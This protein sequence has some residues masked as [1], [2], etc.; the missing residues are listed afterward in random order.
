[1]QPVSQALDEVKEL[2]QKV[3]G[4]PAPEIQPG[5]FVSF[6]PGV[7]PLDHVVKEVDQ[8]KHLSERMTFAPR[9]AAW[10]P[11]ADTFVTP[12]H[13]LVRM[14]IPGVDRETLKVFIVGGEC[15]VR[16]DRKF[17]EATPGVR[18]LNLERAWGPFERRFTLPTGSYPDKVVARYTDGVLEV[19]VAVE[20]I[21]KPREMNVE[22][23]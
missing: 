10:T 14:E 4:K 23:A 3:L 13:Y 21:E 20:G 5:S 1:M 17:Q 6:P 7:D 16:G 15:V 22:V 18:P 2:Y 11:R 8:L 12:E 9:P 19:K